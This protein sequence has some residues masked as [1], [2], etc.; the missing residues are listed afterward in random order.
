M[1]LFEIVSVVDERTS[2][3]KWVCG[4]QA[5]PSGRVAACL[6]AEQKLEG[7]PDGPCACFVRHTS[8]GVMDNTC[9]ALIAE[10]GCIAARGFA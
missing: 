9:T 5:V 2:V 6:G 8:D 10:V 1:P 3:L 4:P 7:A